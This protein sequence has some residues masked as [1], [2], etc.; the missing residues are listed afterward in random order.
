MSAP[1]VTKLEAEAALARELELLNHVRLSPEDR[2][3][4]LW[5]SPQSLVAPR[6]LSKLPGYEAVCADLARAGW[7]VS[8][9]A[10]GGDVTPQGPGII[11]V[12]H[13]YA[14]RP[15][16]GFGIEE[17]YNALCTPIEAALGAGAS[18]GWQPGAFCDGAHNVQWN[19]L[20]FAGTAMRFKRCAVD[21]G[22]QAI[23]AHAL[24]LIAPPPPEA[25]EALNRFL[26]TLSEP[27]VINLAA[28]TGLP[29]NLDQG[30]FLTR[31]VAAFEDL[32][33]PTPVQVLG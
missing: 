15:G 22:R 13:V 14:T 31:L 21:K 16:Q 12:S 30:T 2:F 11:N 7:P 5:Q 26:S 28:H 23:L 27:R 3:L 24:M 10:T 17:G 25:I 19:G 6:K 29:P 8:L 9:R 4:W 1:A 33:D 32:P 18:R 20:K